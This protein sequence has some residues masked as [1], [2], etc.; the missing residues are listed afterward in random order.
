MKITTAH[1]DSPAY[2]HTLRRSNILTEK[3]KNKIFTENE[4]TPIDLRSKN[5]LKETAC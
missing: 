4:Q 5:S 1:T 2:K 3:I